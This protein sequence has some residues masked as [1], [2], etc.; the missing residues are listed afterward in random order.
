L[1]Q[2]VQIPLRH[3]FATPPTPCP[4]ID[5]KLERKVVTLLAAEDPNRLHDALSQAG[6]RRSQDLAYRPACDDCNAC[7]PVRVPV[8]TFVP[9]RTQRRILADTAGVAGREL[10]PLATREHYLLFRRYILSRHAGGGMA[11]MDYADYRAMVEDSPVSTVLTEFREADN[12][13]FGVCLTD[14]MGDGVSLVYS[15]YEPDFAD[16]SPGTAM[17]LHQIRRVHD[18]GRPFVY[19]GYWIAASRKMA[20]KRNF[21]PLESLS[22][23]G[24]KPLAD[25]V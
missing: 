19:L 18:Q 23:D 9:N 14:R 12:R 5:G 3:F 8:A 7:V 17:I 11:D 13:L 25:E 6:F 1:K 24:W 22:A 21:R 10:P 20:Y 4:Y 15:F 16:R 2:R